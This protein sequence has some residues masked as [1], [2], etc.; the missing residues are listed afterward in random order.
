[1]RICDHHNVPRDWDQRFADPN[2]IDSPPDPLLVEAVDMLPP[3][4][5]L[6]LACGAGRHALFLARLG[7]QVT[8]VDSSA[9]AIRRLKSQSAGL[10]IDARVA[11]LESGQFLILPATYD[12]IA[13]F[14]YLQRDL[15]PEIRE[16]IHPGG[17]FAGEILLR[18]NPAATPRNPDFQLSSGELRSLFHGWKVLFYSEGVQRGHSH[19]TA[20]II[21]RRA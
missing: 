4:R 10:A 18:E 21:A 20:R 9:A 14:L 6:D 13:D 12:L 7:W 1:M 2:F 19:A 16:G 17:I 11:D 8:A 5:A 15:F 3:G